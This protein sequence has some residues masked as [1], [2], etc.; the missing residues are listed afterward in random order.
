MRSG[1]VTSQK[2]ERGLE[3]ELKEVK[4]A[5]KLEKE[6]AEMAIEGYKEGFENVKKEKDLLL[7]QLEDIAID[8]MMRNRCDLMKEYVAGKHVDWKPEKWI[9]E[10]E[11]R[12]A[13]LT[14][15]SEDDLEDK[16]G[17]EMSKEIGRDTMGMEI[18]DLGVEEPTDPAKCEDVVL[19]LPDTEVSA[20]VESQEEVPA[21]VLSTTD[22]GEENP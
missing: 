10:Y 2:K 8:S 22:V 13:G 7:E 6:T 15:S 11:R 1:L 16:G 14:S 19:A 3:K 17:E 9:R 12:A 4:A 20:I 21:T 18:A 5:L